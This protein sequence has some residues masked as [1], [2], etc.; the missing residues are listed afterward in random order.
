MK[1]AMF[2]LLPLL[3]MLSGCM[4]FQEA[5]QKAADRKDERMHALAN[6]GHAEA[7][8]IVGMFFNNGMGGVN[9][10]PNVAFEW[11]RKAEAGGDALAAYKMGCYYA[12]QFP[13]TVEV[14]EEKALK[15]KLI[16]AKAGYARAQHD[17]G[18]I[19][20]FR[21]DFAEAERWWTLAAAQGFQP[22]H[23]ALYGLYSKPETGMNNPPL[24]YA[25]YKLAARNAK[26]EILPAAMPGLTGLAEKLTPAELNTA[27]KFV[28][29]FVPKPTQLT[30][31][32][33]FMRKRINALYVEAQEAKDKAR[34]AK[35]AVKASQ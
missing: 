10:N 23:N 17:V 27:D 22:S 6:S 34:E 4:T 15:Y 28:E 32:A 24:A 3:T 31:D 11:F 33:V 8:Y 13:G 19:Y 35:V 25:R 14:D 7:Q 18:V 1:M 21:K 30:V 5:L 29:A 9:R 26:N 2:V 16:A 12:D 20:V